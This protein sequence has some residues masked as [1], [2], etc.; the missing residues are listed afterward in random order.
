MLTTRKTTLRGAL[1]KLEG[2]LF[3]LDGTIADTE[4]LHREAFNA[5]FA[6]AGLPW[7]WGPNRYAEL[8]HVS[9]GAER[10]AFHV[11]ALN[12]PAQ[13]KAR[14]LRMVPAL[15]REKTRIHGELVAAR[16]LRARPGVARLIEEARGAG[17][18]I[19][20]AATSASANVEALLAS[21]FGGD[22][23]AA[24]GAIVCADQV[25]RKKPAPDLYERL[26]VTLGLPA[27]ACVAFEDSENGLA[28]AKAAGLYTVVTPTRWTMAQDFAGADLLL[29][30][31]GDPDAAIVDERVRR[32]LNAPWLALVVLAGR[33]ATAAHG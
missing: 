25:A 15:H 19:G 27:S 11:D 3:D 4:E 8:L 7:H 10:I 26:L 14:F 33:H 32:Q 13:E 30:T 29:P 1:M 6:E 12:A 2:L 28:A 22:G 17:L 23:R 9:G 5:T 24:I 31:L 18:R 16:R 21:V 20:I